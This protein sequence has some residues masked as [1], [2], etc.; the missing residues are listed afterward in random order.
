MVKNIVCI[1]PDCDAQLPEGKTKYCSDTCYKRIS[2]RIHRAKKKGETYELPVKEINQPKSATVRRGSLYDKFR[3]QGYAS[4]LIKDVITRQ[5][6]ADALGCTAG[7]VA[8]M[9]AA[10]REDLEKDIQAENWEVSDDA[11]QSLE[12]FKNFRDRYFLTEQGVP[13]ETAKF[14]NN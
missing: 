1:A 2:Q 5:E 8:R 7:H 6:V 11:K 14:H 13:F 12:D 9:L 10:Y 4:E 3:N